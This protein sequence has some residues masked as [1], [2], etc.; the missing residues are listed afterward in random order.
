M[1]R[2][3]ATLLSDQS[4]YVHS[5]CNRTFYNHRRYFSINVWL[6][7]SFSWSKRKVLLGRFR[8]E[9][10]LVMR[11]I[12]KHQMFLN[13]W[14]PRNNVFTGGQT[15]KHLRKHRESQMFPQECF[16]VCPELYFQHFFELLCARIP[17]RISVD[18]HLCQL[19]CHFQSLFDYSCSKH[20]FQC[21]IH[22]YIVEFFSVLFSWC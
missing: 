19:L 6:K 15:G 16:L 4:S 3:S 5:W 11:N 14:I 21:L 13:F 9:V 20:D 1:A 2:P 7:I 18:R 10:K 22:Y 17:T 8:V 12:G